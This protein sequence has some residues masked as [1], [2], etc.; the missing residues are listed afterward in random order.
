MHGKLARAFRLQTCIVWA[1]LTPFSLAAAESHEPSLRLDGARDGVVAPGLGRILALHVYLAW[2]SALTCTLLT[3]HASKHCPLSWT[4][5]SL[6]T[7]AHPIY[8]RFTIIVGASISEA[9]MRPDPR[10]RHNFNFT[11]KGQHTAHLLHANR[12]A[13][14]A[15]P[16]LKVPGILGA[17]VY[18]DFV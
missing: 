9:A 18:G 17:T 11:H 16:W 4:N 12:W 10:W 8:T 6:C 14:I 2:C 1:N 5:V 3:H 13:P 15:L 7:A